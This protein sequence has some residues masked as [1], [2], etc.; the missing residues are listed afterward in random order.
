MSEE[1]PTRAQARFHRRVRAA[2]SSRRAFVY[3]SVATFVLA[4]GAGL[5]MRVFDEGEFKSAGD[6][7]WWAIV[8]ISTVGYGDVVP[9]SGWGRAIGSVVLVSGVTLVAFLTAT[10][11]SAFVANDQADLDAEADKKRAAEHDETRQLL[12]TISARLD[13]IEK[14]LDGDATSGRPD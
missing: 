10:V 4:I 2:V 14:R 1:R 3:L 13:E 7:V 8:T 5:L 12:K 6:G 9:S 11:T